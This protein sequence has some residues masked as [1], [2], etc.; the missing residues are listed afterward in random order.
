M[1]PISLQ[2]ARLATDVW[3]ARKA[4]D[5]ARQTESPSLPLLEATLDRLRSNLHE[6]CRRELDWECGARSVEFVR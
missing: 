5:V 3:R 6:Q 2:T 4:V 1:N